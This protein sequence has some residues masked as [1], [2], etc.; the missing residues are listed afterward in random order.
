MKDK[1]K[2]KDKDKDKEKDKDKTKSDSD[3]GKPATVKVEKGP[4]TEAVLMTGTVQSE[5]ATE[6]SVKFKTWTGPLVTRK[7]VDHGT[8]VKAGEVLIE[9]ETD[10]I[11]REIR[12]AKAGRELAELA[13]KQAEQEL[14]ILEKQTP[15]ELTLAERDHKQAI[16]DM[17]RFDEIDRKMSIQLAEFSLKSAG[18]Y[19]EYSKD[20]LK[21]LQKMYRDKDLTEETETMILKRYKF[22]VESAEQ[23]LTYAKIDNERTLKIELPRRELALKAAV[24]KAAIALSRARDVQPLVLQQ[25]RLALAQLRHDDEKAKQHLADLE[26]DRATLT[27]KAPSDGLAY[28]GRFV[29]GKWVVVSGAQGPA[30]NGVGAVNPGDVLL[31][32]VSPSKLVIRADA[33]EKEVAGV[34]TGLVGRF[35]P[36]AFPNRKLPCEVTQVAAAPQDGDFE[37]RIKLKDKATGLVPGMTGSLRFVTSQKRSA[38]T[39]PSYAVFEDAAEDTHYVY[40]VT[41]DGKHERKTIKVGITSGD[42]TEIL[43]GLY[44]GDEILTSKP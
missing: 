4:L 6:L 26:Q 12:D 20:E 3:S 31:T 43:E 17:K 23:Y 27:I 38:L 13:I 14:P 16:E 34:K 41:K 33:E 15:L 30:I 24:D 2:E 11:D 35:T 37:V 18:F 40:R 10:K 8:A 32:V 21:Q 5:E 39:V 29:R 7:A 44:E 9:F 28:Y 1:D 42:K 22:S 36:T 25:K 19:Y